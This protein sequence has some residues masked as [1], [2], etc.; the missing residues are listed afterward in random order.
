MP[1]AAAELVV[2]GSTI[3]RCLARGPRVDVRPRPRSGSGPPAASLRSGAWRLPL[4]RSWSESRTQ[5]LGCG[6]DRRRKR[7]HPTPARSLA[8][9]RRPAAG[10]ETASAVRARLPPRSKSSG[11][12]PPVASLGSMIARTSLGVLVST[13][14]RLRTR[15]GPHPPAASLGST[16]A[17]SLARFCLVGR[18][19]PLAEH[20]DWARSRK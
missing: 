9:V 6:C 19:L 11:R 8:R 13:P 3:A 10:G 14:F 2:L 4:G 18:L 15:S 5:G 12:Y 20:G 16:L 7:S 17:C 1:T